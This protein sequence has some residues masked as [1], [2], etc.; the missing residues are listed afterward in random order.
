[1]QNLEKKKKN[2][3]KRNIEINGKRMFAEIL[4]HPYKVC[5]VLEKY[6][7]NQNNEIGPSKNGKNIK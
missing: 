4:C 3:K 7:K 5:D 1:V 6:W 2:W